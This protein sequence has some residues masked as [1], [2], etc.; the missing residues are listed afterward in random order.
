MVQMWF[1]KHSCV[2]SRLQDAFCKN[3]CTIKNSHRG[4]QSDRVSSVTTVLVKKKRPGWTLTHRHIPSNKVQQQTAAV[5]RG[6][7]SLR[8]HSN[9]LLKRVWW[10]T[11]VSWGAARQQTTTT[12]S[13]TAGQLL[14]QEHPGRTHAPLQQ[15]QQHTVPT[16]LVSVQVR[17]CADSGLN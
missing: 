14:L 3:I 11:G 5:K 1:G 9:V 10:T 6:R 7:V 8:K 15:L 4:V 16:A 13:Q 12:A 17:V 2:T